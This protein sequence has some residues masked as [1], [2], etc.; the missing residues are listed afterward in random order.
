MSLDG[1]G[2][3]YN[4]YR[5]DLHLTDD[6]AREVQLLLEAARREVL[7][8]GTEIDLSRV[9]ADEM[10][11][12]PDADPQVIRAKM[13]KTG[14]TEGVLFNKLFETSDRIEALLADEQRKKLGELKQARQR[15]G[16]ATESTSHAAT[17]HAGRSG[18]HAGSPGFDYFLGETGRLGLT[19]DQLGNLVATKNETRKA[20]LIEQAKLKAAELKLLNVLRDQDG[21]KP[22]PEDTIEAA[23]RGLEEVRGRITKAKALGYLKARGILTKEQQQRVHPP[24]TLEDGR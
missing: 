24:H 6:Q 8:V 9:E 3:I 21:D 12:R 22:M 20:V 11:M 5:A 14:E 2:R 18:D 17:G 4:A 23:V 13:Q 15:H 7:R 19:A 1:I 10:V 16:A